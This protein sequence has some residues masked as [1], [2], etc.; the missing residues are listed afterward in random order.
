MRPPAKDTF[1][2]ETAPVLFNLNMPTTDV[3][4]KKK[5]S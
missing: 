2:E 5:V 4:E 1:V 3:E